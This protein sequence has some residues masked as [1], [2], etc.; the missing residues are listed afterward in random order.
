VGAIMAGI[1]ILNGKVGIVDMIWEYDVD[2]SFMLHYI[3]KK[4]M[5]DRSN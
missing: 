2:G 1:W 5:F 3:S 4:N